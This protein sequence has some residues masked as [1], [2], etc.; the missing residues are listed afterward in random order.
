MAGRSITV[1]EKTLWA[2]LCGRQVAGL[3]FRRDYKIGPYVAN[4][5]C[6]DMKLVIDIVEGDA[7]PA[8][9]EKRAAY[10][11]KKGFARLAYTVDEVTSNIDAVIEDIA[12]K[13]A[14]SEDRRS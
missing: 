7:S 1:P 10:I 5:Y 6:P 2:K 12:R 13:A 8:K 11:Q 9:E 4:F 3:K 14:A